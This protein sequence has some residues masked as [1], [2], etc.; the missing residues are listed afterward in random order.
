M[1]LI[2]RASGA[3]SSSDVRQAVEI[4]CLHL[5]IPHKPIF[6]TTHHRAHGAGFL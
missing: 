6:D 3:T 4:E 1:A 5:E 2:R